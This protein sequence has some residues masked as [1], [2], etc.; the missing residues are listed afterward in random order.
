MRT[1]LALLGLALGLGL[2][3][4]RAATGP[5]AGNV[6]NIRYVDPGAALSLPALA[7]NS[8]S[9][10]VISLGAAV[11]PIGSNSLQF[12]DGV[13]MV[14]LGS[15]ATRITSTI[16]MNG[17]GA[18]WER[19]ILRPGHNGYFRGFYLEGI[20]RTNY[21]QCM[22]GTWSNAV[23]YVRTSTNVLFEDIGGLG[24]TD[25]VYVDQP[26]LPA[27]TWTFRFCNLLSG[28]D[29]FSVQS[30]TDTNAL[31]ELYSCVLESRFG[32]VT[33]YSNITGTA[34]GYGRGTIRLF[35]CNVFATGHSNSMGASSL[36]TEADPTK[37]MLE[38]YGSRFFARNNGQPGGSQYQ[39]QNTTGHRVRIMGGGT[40]PNLGQVAG[41]VEP[42]NLSLQTDTLY[43]SRTG[44]GAIYW[45]N[46]GSAGSLPY[47]YSGSGNPNGSLPAFLPS[48]YTDASGGPG[49][50]AWIKVADAGAATGWRRLTDLANKAGSTLSNFFVG[51]N[52]FV[53]YAGVSNSVTGSEADLLTW[54]YPASL[55]NTNR[56]RLTLT[57]SGGFNGNANA[58]TLKVKLGATDLFSTTSQA[59]SNTWTL[60]TEIVRT[61]TSSYKALTR[62]NGVGP[63]NT[64]PPAYFT[65]GAD[66]L[67]A[68]LTLAIRAQGVA[69]GDV[70]NNMLVVD[71][72]GGPQ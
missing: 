8:A 13:S 11:Y 62:F 68:G 65:A 56:A 4:V 43:V 64:F 72:V 9:G 24:G 14:G 45:G 33:G 31:F 5:G 23:D 37:S 21:Y 15:G 19:P 1:T 35:N 26:I 22:V 69:T 6:Q 47:W 41:D 38:S 2:T 40:D 28:W 49:S 25:V 61:G 3:N 71:F 70:T 66:N 46:Y 29:V 32:D 63:V 36:Y 20:G 7:S 52:V 50:S 55:L 12:A 18:G 67:D 27:P 17:V 57:A 10:T 59:M 51:G 48:F 42:L 34:V 58:K 30:A 53:N 60:V 16:R 54:S 44:S 39:I